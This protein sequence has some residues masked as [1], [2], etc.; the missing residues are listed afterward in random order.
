MKG[1]AAKQLKEMIAG[2]KAGTIKMRG[3]EPKMSYRA[4]RSLLLSED[5]THADLVEDLL[6]GKLTTEQFKNK[7][8]TRIETTIP[9]RVKILP[10]DRIHHKSPLEFAVILSEMPDE[11]LREFLIQSYESQGRTYG[12]SD[13]NTRGS[14]FDE[15]AHTG[16]RPKASKAKIVYPNKLGPDGLREISAHPRGTRDTLYSGVTARPTTVA[17]AKE[18]TEPL[19]KQADK[20]FQLG[21]TAD[22]TRRAEVNAQLRQKGLLSADGD[23]FSSTTSDE[24]IKAARKTLDS[25]ELQKSAALAFETPRLKMIGGV[26]RLGSFIPLVG[27]GLDVLDAKEKITKAA[28]PKATPLDKAQAAIA[29]TTAATA[30][31]PDPVSQTINMVGGAANLVI[32]MGRFLFNKDNRDRLNK[33]AAKSF[34]GAHT[35]RY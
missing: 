8:R 31:L 17:E 32:D 10:T 24:T 19:L 34:T 18:V 6:S 9:N 2:I 11:E 16:A 22:S 13:G 28:T 25:P 29:S 33:G 3:N 5:K 14:S 27:A 12:D 26:A 7:I 30:P 1:L 15:R 21:V 23:I 4:L 35:G 20:D